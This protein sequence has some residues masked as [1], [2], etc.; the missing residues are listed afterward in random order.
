MT[1]HSRLAASLKQSDAAR[2]AFSAPAGPYCSFCSR[3]T[4]PWGCKGPSAIICEECAFAAVGYYFEVAKML[5]A[6]QPVDIGK[7]K[8]AGRTAMAIEEAWLNPK[9]RPMKFGGVA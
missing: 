5:H 2:A 3:D 7:A 1:N 4:G 9:D 6:G 8:R